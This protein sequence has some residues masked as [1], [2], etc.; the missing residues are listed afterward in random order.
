MATATL[1]L[2]SLTLAFDA[3]NADQQIMLLDYLADRTP[4]TDELFT[5]IWEAAKEHGRFVAED[6]YPSADDQEDIADDIA[7]RIVAPANS[8]KEYRAR[9]AADRNGT[10]NFALEYNMRRRAAA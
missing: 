3:L 8:S 9:Q 7:C 1:T 5:G 2:E 4:Y 6:E 10:L